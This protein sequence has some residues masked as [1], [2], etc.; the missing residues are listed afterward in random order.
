MLKMSKLRKYYP[1]FK[2]YS[3]EDLVNK[4][5]DL[6]LTLDEDNSIVDETIPYSYWVTEFK[7]PLVAV[8]GKLD[9]IEFVGKFIIPELES[10]R[11]MYGD[12]DSLFERWW[13]PN[14]SEFMK[15]QEDCGIRVGKRLIAWNKFTIEDRLDIYNVIFK[16]VRLK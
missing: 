8:D 9:S 3:L 1:I 6:R 5:I 13:D 12:P 11:L 16:R 7:T 4:V 14:E 10:L 15:T 2:E